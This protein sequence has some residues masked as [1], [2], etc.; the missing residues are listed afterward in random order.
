VI[1]II[2]LNEESRE[3]YRRGKKEAS[4]FGRRGFMIHAIILL[5]VPT[6]LAQ[7]L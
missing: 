1:C 6:K 5:L 7:Q 2:I 4:P 3:S